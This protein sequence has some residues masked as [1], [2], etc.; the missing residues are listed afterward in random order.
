M[1]FLCPSSTRRH[2]CRLASK[3]PKTRLSTD[4]MSVFCSTFFHSKRIRVNVVN[5]YT[6]T[7]FAIV[8]RHLISPWSFSFVFKYLA[9]FTVTF[10]GVPNYLVVLCF[11]LIDW[12][13]PSCT[14]EQAQTVPALWWSTRRR[15]GSSYRAYSL[16]SSGSTF[17]LF[18]RQIWGDLHSSSAVLVFSCPATIASLLLYIKPIQF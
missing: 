18:L 12:T 7:T 9:L 14:P 8:S 1:Q 2:S 10:S 17:S 4:V 11:S 3:H 16:V 15:T 6:N 5:Q 13:I